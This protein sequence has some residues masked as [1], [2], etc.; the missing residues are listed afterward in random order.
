MTDFAEAYAIVDKYVEEHYGIV[1]TITDVLDPNTGDFNGSWIKID[2]QLEAEPSLF[3]LLHLFG[4]TVQWNVS[5]EFRA[6]G[7]ETT[8]H[9]TDEQLK[10]IYAYEKQATQFSLQLLHECGIYDLDRWVSDWWGAD[11]RWLKHF[12]TTGEKLNQRDVMAWIKPGEA[13]LLTPLP[14][15]EFSPKGFVSRWSF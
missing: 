2:Y 1:S 7:Q 14:I 15:P 12:Y 13:E 3:V 9:A 8:E 10:L 4:H 6:L 11:W 5:E